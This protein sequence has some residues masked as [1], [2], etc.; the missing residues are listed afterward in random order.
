[1]MVRNVFFDESVVVSKIIENVVSLL[2]PVEEE[3]VHPPTNSNHG[4]SLS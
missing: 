3:E 4:M 1:M 2:M